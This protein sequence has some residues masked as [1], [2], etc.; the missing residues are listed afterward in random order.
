MY[1][2][3][4]F[5]REKTK[6]LKYVLYKKRSENEIRQK[7][8]KNIEENLLEDIIDYL[9]E[10]KYIDDKEKNQKTVNNFIALKNLS[11]REIEYKLYSKG[12]KKQDIED[13]IHKNREELNEYEIKSARNIV[14]K[15]VTSLEIEE[16]K[17][18]L[19]K[20]GYKKDN[21]NTALEDIE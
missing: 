4:E 12:I 6:V 18:Y 11:I 19:T 15:K 3:E 5:D 9:K 10:A 2:V 14:N 7:F 16:I 21:V 13:Y 8:S 1:T 17:K 20:K